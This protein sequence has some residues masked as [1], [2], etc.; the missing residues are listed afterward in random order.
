[1]VSLVNSPRSILS[2]S[3]NSSLGSEVDIR[4]TKK[5]SSNASIPASARVS[6]ANRA[7]AFNNNS[8]SSINGNTSDGKS[9]TGAAIPV[10]ASTQR[11]LL[12]HRPFANQFNARSVIRWLH[13]RF[14]I[15]ECPTESTLHHYLKEFQRFHVTDVVR[16]CEP[17]Y[18]A[19]VLEAAGIRVHDWPFKDGD[20]PPSHILKAWMALVARHVVE[21]RNHGLVY[22]SDDEDAAEVPVPCIAVHCVAGLGRAPVLVCAALIEH[23]LGP[24]DAVELVRKYR[25]GALNSRQIAYLA[26]Y[27]RMGDSG[28]KGLK[29][30]GKWLGLKRANN[31]P[32][33]VGNGDVK[34]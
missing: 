12:S 23:G 8:A 26:E 7:Y 19:K 32:G 30:F 16:V 17:T 22:G 6:M 14:L 4:S 10:R 3:L 27:K 1:M 18:D 13:L 21:V 34:H 15:V 11:S 9:V 25:K 20:V 33:N 29:G 31:G 24:L 2:T 28:E 5:N